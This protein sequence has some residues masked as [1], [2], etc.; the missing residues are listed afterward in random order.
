MATSVL[1]TRASFA[2]ITDRLREYV[3]VTDNESDDIWSRAELVRRLHGKAGVLTTPSDCIDASLLEACPQLKAVCNIGVGYNNIDVA[4]CT[5]RGIVVTNTPDVVTESTADLGFAL[6]MAAARRVTEADRFVRRGDWTKSGFH[7]QF[8][9]GDVHGTTL[10]ILGMGRIGRAIARRGALGFDMRV[11]YHSRNRLA[12]ED[13]AE[14][15][16]EYVDKP[17][18]LRE[19]D[20]LML[21]LPYSKDT[22][23]AIGAGELAQM[24]RSATLVNIA[25]GGI[26]DD[27][28]LAAALLTGAIAAAGLD[29]FEGEPRVHKDLLSV[30]N[31]VITP[32]IGCASVRTRRAMADLAVSN[33]VAALGFG[34]NAG[35]PQTPVNR[36]VLA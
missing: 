2:D 17:T 15:R 22:H 21:V 6:M 13:E 28:A 4:A 26:V 12:P 33:L 29:V 14:S 20:H 32:H 19:A 27:A 7:N 24:K 25:R 16:A 35:A 11:I 5:A 9:S 31:V 3:N 34:P 23:H 1:V 8:N 36:E 30:H 18:L 10:G